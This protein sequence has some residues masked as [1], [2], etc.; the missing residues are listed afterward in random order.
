[1]IK[2]FS[3]LGLVFGLL[4]TNPTQGPDC[5]R[6][7]ETAPDSGEELSPGPS[8][9]MLG[10]AESL[11][12]AKKYDEVIRL[13]SGPASREPGNFPVNILLA[14]AQT[15]KCALLKS[16]GDKKYRSL[17]MSPYMTARRLN[18]IDPYR[19]E[20]YYIASKCLLINDRLTR[21]I[22]SIKKALYFAPGR[23]EYLIV[24]GDG[25]RRLAE[26]GH[27]RFQIDR[28]ISLA[29][30]A[31]RKALTNAKNE[32]LKADAEKRIEGLEKMKRDMEGTVYRY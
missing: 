22:R 18:R 12:K 4:L 16:R 6:A 28:Y 9:G 5:A 21:S 2:F 11:F 25:C 30:D 19:P 17:V 7:Q 23:P 13:L 1:M 10:R 8:R 15:E 14:K 3:M 32:E 24:L 26:R 20:P 27:D 29:M 31:Y